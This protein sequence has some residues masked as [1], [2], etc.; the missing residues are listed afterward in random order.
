[1][2]LLWYVTTPEGVSLDH[3][4]FVRIGSDGLG[5]APLG[6]AHGSNAALP[7]HQTRSEYVRLDVARQWP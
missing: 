2:D 5:Q 6:P 3:P 1:V 4:H 7:S